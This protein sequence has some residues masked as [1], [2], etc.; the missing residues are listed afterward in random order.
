MTSPMTQAVSEER[1][2]AIIAHAKAAGLNGTPAGLLATMA[3]ELLA[4]R[5]ATPE[6][7][8]WQGV[9]PDGSVKLTRVKAM[10]EEW[11]ATDWIVRALVP[12]PPSTATPEPTFE[13]VPCSY[14]GGAGSNE[15]GYCRQCGGGGAEQRPLAPLPTEEADCCI[16]CAVALK[17][18]DL[19]LDD[20][21]GGLIHAACCGPE[22]ESYVNAD[23]DPLG[24]DDPIPTGWPWQPDATPEP[25][26]ESREA[27]AGVAV[28]WINPV[29]L[30][31]VAEGDAVEVVLWRSQGAGADAARVPLFASPQRD[32]EGREITKVDVERAAV[33]SFLVTGPSGL[34]AL[35]GNWDDLGDDAKHVWRTISRAALQSQERTPSP[36]STEAGREISEAD[37]DRALA[38]FV[39]PGDSRT[40]MRRAITAAINKGGE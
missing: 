18:G 11:E 24:P 14:C 33:A 31:R 6:P 25:S 26:P 1:L 37:V 19:V 23:G 3:R 38:A 10:A 21:S 9:A 13:V 29:W 2:R 30:D 39:E 40:S 16:A 4:L 35:H 20:A 32:T 22:R 28:A 27:E 34:G 7:V 15:N 36:P 17:P 8:A 12:A 5:S